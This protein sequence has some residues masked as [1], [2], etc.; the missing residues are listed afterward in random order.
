MVE[1][2]VIF[3]QY[4]PLYEPVQSWLYLC[5]TSIIGLETFNA[6]HLSQVIPGFVFLS[7]SMKNQI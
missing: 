6:G 4:F 3:A 1:L 2:I 5:Q 7:I